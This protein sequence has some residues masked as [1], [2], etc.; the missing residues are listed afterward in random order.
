ME[1]LQSY[2]HRELVGNIPDLRNKSLLDVGSGLFSV[3][4]GAYIDC[5]HKAQ[6]SN[7]EDPEK[8]KEI[9]KN[10]IAL[11]IKYSDKESAFYPERSVCADAR[12]LP[13]DNDRF[14]IVTMGYLLDYFKN[15]TELAQVI[16]E[17]TRVLK[18]G[19]Y[20]LG[21]VPLH[22]MR[23]IHEKY[24]RVKWYIDLP[25]Y[26]YQANIYKR[27]MQDEGLTLVSADVGY[28]WESTQQ[29]TTYYF[30]ARKTQKSS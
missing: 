19:G 2:T 24:R 25:R 17:S 29:Y 14:D 20:L 4:A 30:V 15:K 7:N 6:E 13:F 11:D 8:P 26:F 27:A 10:V 1:R 28:N 3:Y 12:N 23:A 9:Q 22:P 21:D 18:E 5:S 16:S